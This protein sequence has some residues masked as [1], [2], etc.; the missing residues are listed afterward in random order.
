MNNLIQ[1]MK[2][3]QI[4]ILFFLFTISQLAFSQTSDINFK[5]LIRPDFT[6]FE[7]YGRNFSFLKNRTT[8]T[9]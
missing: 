4:I 1:S 9:G 2:F 7:G 6:D 5:E 8:Q 3:L